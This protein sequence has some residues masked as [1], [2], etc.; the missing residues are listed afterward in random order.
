MTSLP[1]PSP[2]E[3]PQL[4]PASVIIEQ[5]Q[6]ELQAF[7]HRHVVLEVDTE[8]QIQYAELRR[9]FLYWDGKQ[10]LVPEV[11]GG[12]IVDWQALL[13]PGMTPRRDPIE[14][15]YDSR[16]RYDTIVNQ[17]KGDGNKF[18]AV[19]GNRSPNPKASPL[20]ENSVDCARKA[21]RADR[22]CKALRKKWK[23]NET[24]RKL[25]LHAWR[26]GTFFLYTP[27]E[28]DSQGRPSPG[29]H[30]HTGYTV[31]IPFYAEDFKKLP[32]LW[33]QYEANKGELVDR[34]PQLLDRM[35]TDVGGSDAI[36]QTGLWTRALLAS[37]TGDVRKVSQNRW[38][39][40]EIW[41]EPMMFNF[42][43]KRFYG[44]TQIPL[45]E[46]FKQQ[47]P[48]GAR[49]TIVGDKIV[50]IVPESYRDVWS[51][52]QPGIASTIMMPPICKDFIPIQD[53]LNNI[54][55]LN[56]ENI[57]RGIPLT[58]VDP[59]VLNVNAINSRNAVPGEF[60][61][62]LPGSSGKLSDAVKSVEVAE[63]QPEAQSF[64][65]QVLELG[66]QITGVLPPIFGGGDS[67]TAREADIKKTQA[68]M[69]LGLV[70]MGALDVWAGAYT[71][72]VKTI[73]LF[74]AEI[75]RQFGLS[76]MDIQGASEL[77]DPE[78]GELSGFT[79]EVEEAIPSTWG[80]RKD[81]VMFLL[82]GGSPEKM[83]VTGALDPA[84]AGNVQDALGLQNWTVPGGNLK[85]YLLEEIKGLLAEKPQM[86]PMGDPM[87]P[88]MGGI[89]PMT[90]MPMEDPMMS[91]MEPPMQPMPSRMPDPII[92]DAM[93]AM[94]IVR[95]WLLSDEGR[96]QQELNPEGWENVKLWAQELMFMSQPPPMAEG[97]EGPLPGE[98]APPTEERLGEPGPPPR[99]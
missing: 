81:S 73:A 53:V 58:L 2:L 43:G 94:P 95:E 99:M 97:G 21:K 7:L 70:W 49:L 8:K 60:V 5:L 48:R 69:Q 52:G 47:F 19:L 88:D 26:D 30:A 44:T 4:P 15:D 55:N 1:Q 92:V 89:D 91:P 20:D 16:G 10:Y 46:W 13:P 83:Q 85:S 54:V 67:N 90:G 63:Y 40:S 72:A 31:T 3:M 86:P 42:F 18:I 51:C 79:V 12:M 34:F 71:N 77:V 68:L 65:A 37:H 33:M 9:A 75:L 22:I 50:D 35:E 32:W 57:E 39:Y 93:A 76:E 74:G 11:R 78:T 64:A 45:R 14:L 27:L 62:T 61:P 41:L 84:N 56:Q 66:R 17:V 25:M 36:S 98:P 82:E 87:Q 6:G 59:N 29:L 38:T 80:Q 28:K 23:V 24:H 96:M